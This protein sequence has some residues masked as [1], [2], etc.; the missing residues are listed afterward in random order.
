VLSANKKL[1]A[2]VSFPAIAIFDAKTD[3]EVARC[4]YF[5]DGEWI[6]ITPDGYYNASPNGDKYLNV[7][8][9][10]N[11]YG[12]E[13]YREA[14]YR[15]DIVKLALSGGSINDLKTIAEVKQPPVVSIVNTPSNTDK[16]EIKVTLKL[17]DQGGGIG[18]I[19]LYLNGS[20]VILDSTRGISLNPK[21]RR[22][23]SCSEEKNQGNLGNFL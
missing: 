18:D 12:I 17:V 23:G 7:R 6:V 8:I 11:V 2:K 16:D 22:K 5:T 10:N 21:E 15:P 9:G 1:Y 4:Y 20:A 19:R 14:F 3:K 13:N